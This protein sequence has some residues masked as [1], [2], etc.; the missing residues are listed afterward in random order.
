MNP[1]GIKRDMK[2]EFLPVIL[3]ADENAYGCARMLYD[4]FSVKPLVFCSKALAPTDY[5]RIL[6]RRT[7][8]DFD[9][10][11]VFSAVMKETL[12]VL[13][14][15]HEK[16]VIVPCA[17][18]YA[19]MMIRLYPSVSHLISNKFI[20]EKTYER[21][22]DKASFY[23]LCL[24]FSLPH[25]QTTV[26]FP[27][28]VSEK[29]LPSEY[30]VVLKPANSNLSSYLSLDTENKRKVYVC[31]SSEQIMQIC[32]EL[33]LSGYNERCVIQKYI[34]GGENRLRVINSYSDSDGKVRLIGA[35]KPLLCFHDGASIG[36]YAVLSTIKD[37]ELCDKAADFL[38]KLGYVGFANF[39]LKYDI[40]SGEY[41]FFE[42][43]PR[44]G[45][46]SYYINTA[47]KNLMLPLIEECVYS[48]PFSERQYA[49]NEGIF[50]A[51]PISFV[52]KFTDNHANIF[53]AGSRKADCAVRFDYDFSPMR[54]YR[55]T[56][57]NITLLKRF[58]GSRTR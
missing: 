31:E 20:P 19:D 6:T 49:E 52:E 33:T 57:R 12:T 34:P 37:R 39:D 17:D 18:Y 43:N 30:P 10:Y 3:G 4:L 9:S 8:P 15:E 50:T 44:P 25:P 23:K 14:H 51:V 53:A 29:D 38:E 5:S 35:A 1:K 24:E 58:D 13:R 36:N 48:V 32:K 11:N 2:P 46:S 54:A 28:S 42:I 55:L 21:F 47:G 22:K 41:V 45:R 40:E 26:V 7:I 56:K 27:S 16:I